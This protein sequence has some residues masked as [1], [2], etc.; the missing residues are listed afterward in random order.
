MAYTELIIIL[1]L[2][3]VSGFLSLSEVSI[4]SSRKSRLKSAAKNG[5]SGYQ[6]AFMLADDPFR[7][8]SAV[9]LSVTVI[10][11]FISIYTAAAVSGSLAE[12]FSRVSILEPYAQSLSFI[13]AVSF[14]TYLLI[15]FGILIPEKIGYSCPEQIASFVA[16][17]IHWL[18]ILLSPFT[19]FVN[20]S[21]DFAGKIFGLKSY[22]PET[23]EEDVIAA[24]Q[25]GIDGGSIDETEQDL[26]ERV[27]SL[28]DR[29]VSSL[30]THKNDLVFI[31][32]SA[33][34]TEVLKVI[35]RTP[36]SV[37]PVADGGIDNIVGI[38]LVKELIGEINTPDF[39]LENVMQPVSF[40]PENMTIL[41]VLENFREAQ[42]PYAI[43]TDEFGSITGLVTLSDIFEALAGDTSS[44][45]SH[46]EYEIF[47]RSPD[48]WLIDG[49][50][51][52]YDFLE[53]FDLLDCRSEYSYNTL[54]GMILD[55]FGKI[56]VVGDKLDW[57]HFEIEVVDMD[58]ARID[59]V[60]VTDK[61]LL[62][63]AVE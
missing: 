34:Q 40:L 25:E 60:L 41:S 21:A 14:I 16:G 52:F 36:F 45:P 6:K 17:P 49:Q 44:R 3:L 48:S 11:V 38:L 20:G 8:L 46:E 33:T 39:R 15:V 13:A 19:W 57:L 50:Y 62:T 2:I 53:Y 24:V 35:K 4:T 51:P 58:S 29:K 32:V 55:T 5:Q 9:R 42:H 1:I 27:F 43:I 7:A 18:S 23:T 30:I 56:P 26:V 31:D 54:S 22:E 37:Y 63:P 47:K 12:I 61:G 59:K 10:S 28:D